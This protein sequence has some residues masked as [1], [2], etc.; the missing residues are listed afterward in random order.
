M[1]L[2]V[3]TV[4]KDPVKENFYKTME[5]VV[6][7]TYKNFEY[8]VKINKNDNYASRVFQKYKKKSKIKLLVKEDCHLYD[9]MNQA[10][11]ISKGEFI[12]YLNSGDYFISRNTLISA[13]SEIN[14]KNFIYYSDFT[15]KGTLKE[16]PNLNRMK[17]RSTLRHEAT[18]VPKNLY[19]KY[20][21]LIHGYTSED[22]RF[23]R[24]MFYNG[25][26]F[27]KLSIPMTDILPLGV[28]DRNRISVLTEW[29][30]ISGVSGINHLYY[31]FWRVNERIKIFIKII[32]GL[33]YN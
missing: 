13:V 28:S 11:E 5:S 16:I 6:S 3:I 33:K 30:D 19:D 17:F 15:F 32:L 4:V 2:T 8:I 27:K 18:I 12:I 25:Q 26:Q 24:K 22:F 23:F 29:E 9:A 21:F 10:R 20:P 14:D 1:Y 7:Q 31:K